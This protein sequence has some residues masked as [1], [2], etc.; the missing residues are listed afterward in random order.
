MPSCGSARVQ[1]PALGPG[2]K[3]AL[4][5]VALAFMC[6]KCLPAVS[7]S[8]HESQHA[9]TDDAVTLP[10]CAENAFLQ[11]NMKALMHKDIK[12]Y[13]KSLEIS[14]EVL[15]RHQTHS[16]MPEFHWNFEQQWRG[17]AYLQIQWIHLV[18]KWQGLRVTPKSW[19]R[20]EQNLGY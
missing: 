1:Q 6:R 8:L 16:K 13:S 12:T 4:Q 19:M 3:A 18:N 20:P 10:L 5:L 2:S 17:F 7:A 11:L 9:H 15:Q 14:L